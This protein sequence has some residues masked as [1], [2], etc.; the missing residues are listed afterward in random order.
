MLKPEIKYTEKELIAKINDQFGANTLNRSMLAYMRDIR[1][2]IP[3]PLRIHL[4]KKRGGAYSFYREETLELLKLIFKEKIHNE[5]NLKE[6]QSEF[7]YEIDHAF[8]STESY[9]EQINAASRNLEV[10]LEQFAKKMSPALESF[11]KFQL[12]APAILRK[13]FID[14][15][16]ETIVAL[17]GQDEEKIDQAIE[18][19]QAVTN[20]VKKHR[21]KIKRG[22]IVANDQKGGNK[23]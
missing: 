20:V 21:L 4:G 5:K 16:R 7:Q 10:I 9:R 13:A 1:K 2:L 8:H 22:Q 11:R 3:K 17:E 6:I 23:K 12:N 15:L 14:Q 19:L 18:D